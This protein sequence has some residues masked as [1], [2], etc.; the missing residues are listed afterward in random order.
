MLVFSPEDEGSVFVQNISLY[1]KVL[2]FV[3]VFAITLSGVPGGTLVSVNRFS[4]L[5]G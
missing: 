3:P 1:L 5:C 2:L 4:A